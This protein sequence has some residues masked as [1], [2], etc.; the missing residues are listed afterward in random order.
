MGGRQLVEQIR[1]VAPHLQVLYTSG[2]TFDALGDTDE[3]ESD[4][5]FLAKPYD[6]SQLGEKVYASLRRRTQ[7]PP[8]RPGG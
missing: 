8:G 5:N 7:P 2:Y 1:Q 3:F 4:C 6:Q